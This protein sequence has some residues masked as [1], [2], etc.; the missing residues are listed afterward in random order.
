MTFRNGN[1]RPPITK[2]YKRKDKGQHIGIL[3]DSEVENTFMR[4][5]KGVDL[6]D[7]EKLVEVDAKQEI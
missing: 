3:K 7:K 5:Q 6:G 1:V 4:V 2:V